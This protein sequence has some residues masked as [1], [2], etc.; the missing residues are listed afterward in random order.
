[1][2]EQIES[3]NPPQQATTSCG[4]PDFSIEIQKPIAYLDFVR[5]YLFTL[6]K[7]ADD[8]KNMGI[9][10]SPNDVETISWM[11]SEAGTTLYQMNEAFYGPNNN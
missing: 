6:S 3:S 5:D 2:P 9:C 4:I 10:L 7:L 8:P 1:M 11:L